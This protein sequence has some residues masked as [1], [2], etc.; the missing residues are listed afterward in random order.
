MFDLVELIVDFLPEFISI[1]NAVQ[2]AREGEAAFDQRLAVL[3]A[4]TLAHQHHL[5]LRNADR[6]QV[7]GR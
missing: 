5:R 4:V 1:R 2:A 6:D 3:T 7:T